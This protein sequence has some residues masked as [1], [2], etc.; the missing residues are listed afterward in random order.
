M[1]S[2]IKM[3]R[4]FYICLMAFFV[5]QSSCYAQSID[6]AE[7]DAFVAELNDRCPMAFDEDFAA[8]S[9]TMV[10]DRYALVDIQVPASLSMILPSLTADTDNV[11]QLWISQLSGYGEPWNRF[12]DLM[13][14]AGCSIVVSLRPQGNDDTA[15]ITFRPSDFKKE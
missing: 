9:F 11:K 3:K 7:L 2:I 10:G 5:S 1:K 4:L 12:V 15:L 8:N 14:D 6:T 13:V